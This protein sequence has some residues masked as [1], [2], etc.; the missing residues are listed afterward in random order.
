MDGACHRDSA[1]NKATSDAQRVMTENSKGNQL[2]FAITLLSLLGSIYSQRRAKGK[3]RTRNM[4]CVACLRTVSSE[5][6]A[7]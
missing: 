6:V 7:A 2:Y 5:H 4:S 1:G 3:E